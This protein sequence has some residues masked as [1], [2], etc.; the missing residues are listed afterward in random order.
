MSN[1]EENLKPKYSLNLGPWCFA[2]G[3]KLSIVTLTLCIILVYLGI[4]QLNRA[5]Y[6]Q[7]IIQKLQTKIDTQPIQLRFIQYPSL[8]KDQF[9]PVMFDGVYLNKYTFLLDNQMLDHKVGFR[10]LTP[11][12]S[13]GLDKWVL[14][15]R[16]WVPLDKDRQNLPKIEDIYG[17]KSIKGI[18]NTISTGIILQKDTPSLIPNWPIIIQNLDYNFISA[19][20]Q[21]QIY[22][23]IVQL[24]A[25][26]EFGVSSHKHWGYAAQWF[27]FALLVVVYYVIAST[28]RRS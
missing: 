2:P 10:V 17:V 25:P 8:E 12:Q 21:H 15:D 22:P 1:A 27:I 20:L 6:K 13:P 14:I 16:G 26:T 4:W 28:K 23:F 7:N 19:Q 11:F 9:T 5:A 3:I 18:I 24:D